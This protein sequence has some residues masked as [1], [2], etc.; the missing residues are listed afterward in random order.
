MAKEDRINASDDEEVSYR[1]S[2]TSKP[3]SKGG[4]FNGPCTICGERISDGPVSP[5]G[6]ITCS[7]CMQ[8]F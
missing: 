2:S 8:T 5:D 7:A 4:V 6:K 1:S 3:S